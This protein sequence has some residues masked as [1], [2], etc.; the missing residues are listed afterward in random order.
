MLELKVLTEDKIVTCRFE[1]SLLS[2]SKWEAIHK[3]PFLNERAK[4]PSEMIS[5]Y[6]CMLVAPANRDLVVMLTPEQMDEMGKYINDSRTASSVPDLDTP[7]RGPRETVTSELIYYW[8][9]GLQIPFEAEKWH[10]SRLLMLI[11]ITNFKQQPAEKQDKQKLWA[12]Y[13]EM[14]ERNKE[15]Y[16]TSG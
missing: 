10:I 2:L 14:N 13:R 4:T 6:E 7:Q 3:K 11:R 8:M 15:K 16:N 9:V 1:H 5:Y 12:R